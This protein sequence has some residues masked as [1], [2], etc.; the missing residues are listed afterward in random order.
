MVMMFIHHYHVF[1]MI[2]MV[3]NAMTQ[4]T[5]LHPNTYVCIGIQQGKQPTHWNGACCNNTNTNLGHHTIANT[6]HVHGHFVGNKRLG[7]EFLAELCHKFGAGT[8]GLANHVCAE[9][10][11][12]MGDELYRAFDVAVLPVS[13]VALP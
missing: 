9:P 11:G 3:G 6:L 10:A 8:C 5:R 2:S 4:T 12:G 1:T 13:S 7:A